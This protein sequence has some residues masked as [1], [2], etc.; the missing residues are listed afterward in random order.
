MRAEK[1]AMTYLLLKKGANPNIIFNKTKT[2][3][4][5]AIEVNEANLVN[6]LLEYKADVN[7][8]DLNG[9]T[10]LSLALKIKNDQI[11]NKLKWYGAK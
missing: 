6:L 2:P 7:K 1:T 8:K 4:N 11:I 9:I 5:F 3:L 10:P